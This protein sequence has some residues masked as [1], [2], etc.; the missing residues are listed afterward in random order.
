VTGFV[1][2]FSSHWLMTSTS[3]IVPSAVQTGCLKGCRLAAQKL[4]GSLLKDAPLGAFWETLD[5]A[6]AEYASDEDHS[7]WVIYTVLET[8]VPG[9]RD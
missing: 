9:D 2:C 7:E 6:L 3:N 5:P 4:N 8:L 1:P